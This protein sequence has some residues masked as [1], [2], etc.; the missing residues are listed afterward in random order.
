MYVCVYGMYVYMQ[1]VCVS[2]CVCVCNTNVDILPLTFSSYVYRYLFL[3]MRVI[4]ITL[5]RIGSP[6]LH[7]VLSSPSLMWKHA[8]NFSY[9]S[10]VFTGDGV[11]LKNTLRGRFI[12]QRSCKLLP[13][14][15]YFGPFRMSSLHY[16]FVV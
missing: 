11:T 14:L 9:F 1:S 5:G 10:F 6:T 2:V 7:A 12:G 15:F 4:F 16:I 13:L 3:G 8:Y